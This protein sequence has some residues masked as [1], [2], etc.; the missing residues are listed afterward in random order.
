M[1]KR[2]KFRSKE[3]YKKIADSNRGK[4]RSLETCK[5]ISEA[6]KG[7][8]ASEETKKLLSETSR[9]KTASP[10]QIAIWKKELGERAETQKGIVRPHMIKIGNDRK[11]KT[12]EEIFGKEVAVAMDKANSDKHKG[13]EPWNKGLTVSTDVRVANYI[14]TRK[15]NDNYGHT[16]ITKKRLSEVGLE[17][18]SDPE[19]ATNQIH[20]QASGR[21]SVSPTSYEEKIMY[22]CDKYGF[23]FAFVGNWA[24]VV[25]RFCP[26]FVDTADMGLLIE[27]YCD[28]WHE[29]DYAVTRHKYFKKRGLE[30]LFLSDEDLNVDNWEMR[31]VGKMRDFVLAID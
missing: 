27:T 19:Y 14:Q 18:W 25:G 21:G 28:Y 16:D 3:H 23:P 22:I 17:K 7:T 12:H 13:K 4:K 6:K 31:C 10:E 1:E 30:T 29:K 2:A 11:G 9:W 5:R 15:D 24:F 8:V 26:D 20:A